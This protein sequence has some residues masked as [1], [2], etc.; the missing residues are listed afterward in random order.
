MIMILTD[1]N[2][3]YFC[4]KVEVFNFQIWQLG[5]FWK[6][7]LKI[8]VWEENTT[9]KDHFDIRNIEVRGNGLELGKVEKEDKLDINSF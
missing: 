7:Y 2:N 8:S 6:L 1:T 5:P 3:L 9:N 4:S